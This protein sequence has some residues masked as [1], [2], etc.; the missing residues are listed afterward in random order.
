MP[1]RRTKRMAPTI[2]MIDAKEDS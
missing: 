2:H 1:I